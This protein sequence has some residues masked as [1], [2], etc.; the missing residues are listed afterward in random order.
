[1]SAAAKAFIDTLDDT[2]RG[3]VVED[4]TSAERTKW[5]NL[6][7]RSGNGGLALGKCN[8]EQ[9]AFIHQSF[10]NAPN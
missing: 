4:L 10:P 5:T 2:Q 6:P 3:K 8:E 9:I 7:Q 1:M